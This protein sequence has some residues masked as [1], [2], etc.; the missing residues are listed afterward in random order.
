MLMVNHNL[1]LSKPAWNPRLNALEKY[2]CL[3]MDYWGEYSR[4]SFPE[5][6]P[7]RMPTDNMIWA[8]KKFDLGNRLLI[9]L[10]FMHF[11]I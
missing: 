4:L 3:E 9:S 5:N 1:F 2:G 8:I 10:H 7:S 11:F 6:N